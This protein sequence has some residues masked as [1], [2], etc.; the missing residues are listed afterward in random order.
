M[1]E[2]R[3]GYCQCLS[4]DKELV[5]HETLS[6]HDS[7]LIC[8]HAVIHSVIDVERKSLEELLDLQIDKQLK[9]KEQANNG[10]RGRPSNYDDKW[11]AK[12]NLIKWVCNKEVEE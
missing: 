11:I 10:K 1:K 5:P 4:V 6:Q 12:L 7:C 9:A 8:N 2:L 3:S